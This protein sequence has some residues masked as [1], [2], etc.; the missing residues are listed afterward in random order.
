M[1]LKTVLTVSRR[2][3]LLGGLASLPVL[4]DLRVEQWQGGGAGSG[5]FTAADSAIASRSPDISATSALV[6]FSDAGQ[7]GAIAGSNAWP[8][9]VSLGQSGEGATANSD[10]A[11]RI[12]GLLN[13]SVADTYRFQTY[14][15]DGV[16]LRIGG[17]TVINDNSYHAANYFTGSIFLNPGSYAVDLLF[18]EAG[19]QATLEFAMARSTGSFALVG[20]LAGTS[21]SVAPV[22]EPS[23]WAAAIAGIGIGLATWRRARNRSNA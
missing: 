7:S 6:D 3:V 1:N 4:G 18:F 11:A 17:T 13:I 9:A 8:L 23:T 20:S 22:P 14:N 21:T 2:V 15:D 19:G 12:T 16:R 10:F 5:G